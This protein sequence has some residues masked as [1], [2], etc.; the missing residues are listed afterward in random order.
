MATPIWNF[1]ENESVETDKVELKTF[2]PTGKF[3]ADV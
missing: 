1:Q 2:K 3:F